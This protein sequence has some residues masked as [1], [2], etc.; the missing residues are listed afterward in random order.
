MSMP[1]IPNVVLNMLKAFE[2]EPVMVNVSD[3]ETLQLY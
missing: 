2:E 1:S 3:S